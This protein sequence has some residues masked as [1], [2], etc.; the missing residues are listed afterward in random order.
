MLEII[1]NPEDG[2]TSISRLGNTKIAM[3]DGQL[4]FDNLNIVHDTD[5]HGVEIKSVCSVNFV[6]GGPGCQMW[7]DEA[8]GRTELVT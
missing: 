8:L 1:S 5:K 2:A 3:P 7:V 4:V 6:H